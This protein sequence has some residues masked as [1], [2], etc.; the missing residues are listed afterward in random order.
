MDLT[1]ASR[2]ESSAAV[3]ASACRTGKAERMRLREPRRLRRVS[4]ERRL[5]LTIASCDAAVY[6]AEPAA[7]YSLPRGGGYPY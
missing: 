2:G 6:Q 7:R 1:V 3:A 4:A 5:E